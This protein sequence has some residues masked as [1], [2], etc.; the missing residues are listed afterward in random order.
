MTARKT[1]SER[2]DQVVDAAL[3]LLAD[4]P[5][6][7]LT[8]RRLARA[9][10]VSQPALFRHFRSRDEIV[11]AVI[12]RVRR[13][14]G[15]L[16]SE[17][18][19]GDRSPL[20][21]IEALVRGLLGYAAEHPGMPRLLFTDLSGA[22]S[23]GCHAALSQIVSLQRNLLG[24]LIRQAQRSESLPA[25][26]DV[27]QAARLI[28]AMVQGVVLQWQVEGRPDRLD[29]DATAIIETWRT[30]LRAGVPA[31]DPGGEAPPAD[32]SSARDDAAPEPAEGVALLD[33]RPILSRG[34]DPL[35]HVR[36]AL[37]S[38]RDD[39]ALV[40]VAPFRPEPLL[41]LL[42]GQG[43]TTRVEEQEGVHLVTVIGPR[44]APPVDLRPLPAPEPLEQV[45]SM[46]SAL[47]PGASFLA[48]VPRVP[49]LLLPRLAERGMAWRVVGL[50][51]GSALLHVSRPA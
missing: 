25:E 22:T 7:Q 19:A 27:S 28:L 14:M 10:G 15:D 24:E 32:P 8:T 13:D 33:V 51:D 18:L 43:Y 38:V 21:T 12:D 39:G 5:L 20:A 41:L 47:V 30:C 2:R 44:A 46:S 6:D 9:V 37:S 16:A 17:L 50:P 1:R 4:V 49:Q 45:L 3:A 34:V 26:V 29:A 40:V 31:A 35:E 42:A 36:S 23:E 48:R 11:A